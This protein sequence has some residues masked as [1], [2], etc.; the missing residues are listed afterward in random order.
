MLKDLEESL[1]N[2]YNP[3]DDLVV[4]RHPGEVSDSPFKHKIDAAKRQVG[5]VPLA[6]L[7]CQAQEIVDAAESDNP[8]AI[9]PATNKLKEILEDLT[10]DANGVIS[11]PDRGYRVNSAIH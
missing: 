5:V 8:A 7:T 3:N 6:M 4:K 2:K 11:D 10:R 9:A 1:L